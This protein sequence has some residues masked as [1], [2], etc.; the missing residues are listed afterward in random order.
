[1]LE[2]LHADLSTLHEASREKK[3]NEEWTTCL[4]QMLIKKIDQEVGFG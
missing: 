3:Q 2:S 4:Q 1:M